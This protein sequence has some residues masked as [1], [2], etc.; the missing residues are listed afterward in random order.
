M[1][2]LVFVFVAIGIVWGIC[3]T[4]GIVLSAL[5]RSNNIG[6]RDIKD[7]EYIIQFFLNMLF[8]ATPILYPATMFPKALRWVLYINP[9]SQLIDAYRNI[10]LYHDNFLLLFQT[11]IRLLDFQI[12]SD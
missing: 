12:L 3:L 10:F 8:Y 2:A 1:G 6:Q 5:V 7:T 9:M 11:Y 4:I